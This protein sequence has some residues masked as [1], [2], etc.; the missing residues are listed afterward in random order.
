MSQESSESLILTITPDTPIPRVKTP[1]LESIAS[2]I[3]ETVLDDSQFG[4]IDNGDS[5]EI[6]SEI[7][8]D[9]ETNNDTID[10]WAI[11]MIKDLYSMVNTLKETI[12]EL[13]LEIS[14]L[15]NEKKYL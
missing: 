11:K 12:H 3:T 5:M 7:S 1:E 13:Q 10:S 8:N 15:K 4:Y 2:S 9:S 14:I 6:A